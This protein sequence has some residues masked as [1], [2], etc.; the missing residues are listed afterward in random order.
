MRPQPKHD[1]GGVGQTEVCLHAQVLRLGVVTN[2][3]VR[4]QQPKIEHLRIR[5]YLYSVSRGEIFARSF[6][7]QT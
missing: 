7:R 1:G 2:G 5:R 6:R 3:E 4:F